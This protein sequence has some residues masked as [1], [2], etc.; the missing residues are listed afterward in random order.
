MISKDQQTDLWRG[1]AQGNQALCFSQVYVCFILFSSAIVL[2]QMMR[3]FHRLSWHL[4]QLAV[5]LLRH[6][7]WI[8]LRP[9][10]NLVSERFR[11]P[12]SPNC[13][14]ILR[15]CKDKPLYLMQRLCSMGFGEAPWSTSLS[16]ACITLIS[17]AWKHSAIESSH[18]ACLN[19][20]RFLFKVCFF[21][22]NCLW[23]AG[24]NRQ[25]KMSRVQALDHL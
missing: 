24:S 7:S 4:L 12:Q 23:N 3:C 25:M 19:H 20:V 8:W 18:K 15:L 2:I 6:Y 14:L 9:L 13:R 5:Y 21:W 10:S 16:L 17:V 1:S 11:K 22:Q